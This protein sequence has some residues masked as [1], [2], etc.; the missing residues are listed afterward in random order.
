MKL[1]DLP[2]KKPGVSKVKLA[3]GA[4]GLLLFIVGVSKTFRTEEEVTFGAPG[5][6]DPAPD[7]RGERGG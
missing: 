5:E 1:E 7:R 4:A 2:G 6:R 3:L